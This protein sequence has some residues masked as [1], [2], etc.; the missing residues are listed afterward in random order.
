[1]IRARYLHTNIIARD[2]KALVH[3]YESVFGC[4]RVPPERDYSGNDL[5]GGTGLPGVGLAGI[6]LRLPGLGDSGPTLEIYQYDTLRDA[7][8]PAVNRPGFTHIAFSV[9]NVPSAQAEVLAA[10]GSSVGSVVVVTTPSGDRIEWC[11]VRDPEGNM[12]ELQSPAA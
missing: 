10:G 9:E 7:P 8:D 4:T 11:Y 1:M 6:H 12:I 2:W 3:F 5:E